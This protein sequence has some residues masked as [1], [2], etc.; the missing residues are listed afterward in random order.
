MFL[1]RVGKSFVDLMQEIIR[2]EWHTLVVDT[3]NVCNLRCPFCCNDFSKENERI[4]MKESIFTKVVE[5]M[6]LIRR[7]IYLSCIFEPTLHPLFFDFLDM[8]PQESKEK[9]FFTTNLTT[10]IPDEAII[11]LSRSGISHLNISLDSLNPIVYES[12]RKGA[13]FED[14]INNLKRLVNIFF[15]SPAAPAIRYITMV[16]K[17]NLEEIPYI[18]EQCHEKYLS[19]ENE[20]RNSPNLSFNKWPDENMISDKEWR[21]LTKELKM[22]THKFRICRYDDPMKGILDK[23]SSKF[24]SH[25]SINSGGMVSINRY[26]FKYNLD[27]MVDPCSFFKEIRRKFII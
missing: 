12:L 5:I 6:P 14:F 10:K 18:L 1:S 25:L 27:T 7:H 26:C 11:K 2:G 3:T 21:V 15:Q 23:L 17:Q 4:F 8:I 9:C 19:S 22:K 24:Q 13:R 16:F 20:F